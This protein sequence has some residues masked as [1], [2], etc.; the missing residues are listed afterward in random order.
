MFTPESIAA[1]PNAIAVA[2][3]L[4][5]GLGLVPFVIVLWRRW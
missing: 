5:I 4:V 2:Q 1:V 3:W